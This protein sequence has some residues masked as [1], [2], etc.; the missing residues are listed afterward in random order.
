MSR[1]CFGDFS[2]ESLHST[3]GIGII[4]CI[5]VFTILIFRSFVLWEHYVY[6][7]CFEFKKDRC[8][9]MET[10]LISVTCEDL[11][12]SYLTD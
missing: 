4:V 11:E 1:N 8:D 2:Y 7:K 5:V 12:Q 3:N 9:C 6:A 10:L